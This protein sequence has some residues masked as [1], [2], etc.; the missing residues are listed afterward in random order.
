LRVRSQS[1]RTRQQP[2]HR[3][4][5]SVIAAAAGQLFENR[6]HHRKP[7]PKCALRRSHPGQ[8]SGPGSQTQPPNA[9]PPGK[10]KTPAGRLTKTNKMPRYSPRT[11]PSASA[12]PPS[13]NP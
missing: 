12:A 4:D 13:R 3:L 6:N 2:P 5:H 1:A 10:R 11:L 7:H 9:K 8:K